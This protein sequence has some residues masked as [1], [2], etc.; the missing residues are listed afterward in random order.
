MNHIMIIDDSPTVRKVIEYTLQDMDYK[1]VHA[2]NGSD[3]LKKIEELKKKNNQLS[4]CFVDINMPVMDGITF[5]KEFRK[6]DRF[7]PI[8]ILTTEG[9]SDKIKEGKEAGAS[10]WILKP[11]KPDIVLDTIKKLIK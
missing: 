2:G 9:S 7:T 4:L 6:K 3:G 1:I 8:V 5:V 10:A 11:F